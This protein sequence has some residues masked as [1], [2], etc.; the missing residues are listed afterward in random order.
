MPARQLGNDAEEALREAAPAS[1]GALLQRPEVDRASTASTLRTMNGK[2][3]STWPMRMKTQLV[4]SSPKP[5]KVTI[6]ARAVP[7]RDGHRHDQQFLD[8]ARQRVP[9]RKHVSER[10]AEQQRAR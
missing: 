7:A 4:R 5:P 8:D 1:A 2:V 6:S 3:N 10:H 9:P